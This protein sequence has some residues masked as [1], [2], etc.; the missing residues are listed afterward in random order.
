MGESLCSM[1]I[2][3][4]YLRKLHEFIFCSLLHLIRQVRLTDLA[5]T[6]LFLL[7][8]CINFNFIEQTS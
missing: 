2:V 1:I 6:F 3:K 5:M 4:C 8:L 7:L